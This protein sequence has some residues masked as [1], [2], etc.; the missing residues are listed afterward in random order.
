LGI[1]VGYSVSDKFLFFSVYSGK[2]W[3]MTAAFRAF[4]YHM[5]RTELKS[6]INS[7][8][9]IRY[10]DVERNETLQ[11][12]LRRV[13]MKLTFFEH[14]R[15][16]DALKKRFPCSQDFITVCC[17]QPHETTRHPD[18]LFVSNLF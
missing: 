18:I 12:L 14:V 11:I 1:T 8:S 16:L 17:P 4:V 7:Y 2:L 9:A 3:V 10:I 15:E 6:K 5:K 13:F